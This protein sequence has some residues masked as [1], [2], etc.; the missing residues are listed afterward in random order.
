MNSQTRLRGSLR[1]TRRWTTLLRTARSRAR[2]V[3]IVLLILL[4][5]LGAISIGAQTSPP[6][7]YQV[8]AAF[9]YNFAKFVE[10]P[11]NAFTDEKSPITLCVYGKDP[12]GSALDDAIRA[13]AIGNRNFVIR[14]TKTLQDLNACQIVFVASSESQQLREIL[15]GLSGSNALIVGESP[16]FAEQVGHIQFLMEDNRIRFAINVDSVNRA[17]FHM[18]SKLLALA[19]IVH[20]TK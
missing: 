14:R 7:E 11:P 3:A 4:K 18:S 13:K 12:F 10:W 8:K 2:L 19:Q 9:I 16:H 17:R 1:Q 5:L 20:D 15:A 6:T